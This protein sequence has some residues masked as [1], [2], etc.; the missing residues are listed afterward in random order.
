MS[1]P[2]SL[3][4]GLIGNCMISALID[5][6]ARIVWC[7]LPR[8]DSSPVFASLLDPDRGGR[9]SVQPAHSFT[10]TQEYVRN[11]CVLVT[12]FEVQDGTAFEVVDFAPRFLRFD[13]YFRPASIIR[14]V[15][16][17]RGTPRVAVRCQP[18]IDY[19]REPARPTTGPARTT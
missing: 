17:T 8:F 1:R 10:S 7:C 2:A 5:P 11:T 19:G 4:L 3:E 14:I 6:S 9:F 16:P 13:R 12:R 18:T 15:R